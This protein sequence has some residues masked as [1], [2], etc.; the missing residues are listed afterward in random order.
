M[1]MF[2]VSAVLSKEILGML[3]VRQEEKKFYWIWK[4]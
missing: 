3:M 1:M 2:F 4:N